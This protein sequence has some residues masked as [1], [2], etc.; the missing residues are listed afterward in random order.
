[1]GTTKRQHYVPRFYLRHFTMSDGM[2]SAYRR[3][4]GCYFHTRPEGICSERFLY[5]SR[6]G[7]DEDGNAFFRENRIEDELSEVEGRLSKGLDALLE[8]REKQDFNNEA[9]ENGRLAACDF[10]DNLIARNPFFLASDRAHAAAI[11][12]EFAREERFTEADW[13]LPKLPCPK[14]DIGQVQV[15]DYQS[16][17]LLC[18]CMVQSI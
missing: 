8:C 12:E 18:P 10:A 1:M 14:R 13:N 2:L 4:N 3:D 5:E 6:I 9:F 7:T 16:I 15:A 11:A 17:R